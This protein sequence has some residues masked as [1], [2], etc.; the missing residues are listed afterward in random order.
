MD[1]TL[2]LRGHPTTLLAPV[3]PGTWEEELPPVSRD[4][5]SWC[6]LR[7]GR[8]SEV[9]RRA[10]LSKIMTIWLF[11]HTPSSDPSAEPGCE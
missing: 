5:G 8:Q 1:A 11:I 9:L 2:A 4:A 7:E 3:V 10:C 6:V